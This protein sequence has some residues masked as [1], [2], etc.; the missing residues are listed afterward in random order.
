MGPIGRR[1]ITTYPAFDPLDPMDLRGQLTPD[2]LAIHESVQKYCDDVL[3]K[4]VLMAFRHAP[5]ERPAMFKELGALGVM[6]PTIE[7]YG[8]AGA[9]SVA[10]GLISRA[11]ES[12]D[13][14]YRSCWSVQS[15]LVMHPINEYGN[16][17]IKKKYLPHLATGD[18]VGCFGLTEPNSGSM[19]TRAVRKGDEYILN[20]TKM[21]ISNAPFADIM[22]IWAKI[23]DTDEI[24]GFVVERGP[25]VTTPLIEGKV[26]LRTSPTG[27]IQLQDVRVPLGNKLNVKGLKGPFGCLS[28]ARY[29]IAWGA[30]GAAES[31][32]K[33]ATQYTIDRKQ[34]GKPLAANQLSLRT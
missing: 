6:G 15:S 13:S 7:G 1:S 33:M 12:V 32:Y 28:S 22:V 4:R 26:S 19:T 21:W 20:G 34:F 25:G 14:G 5:K 24:G 30:L 8:C 23:D 29:G 17:E 3:S 18:M 9:S 27:S 31:C 2:E 11:I 10:M 16:E